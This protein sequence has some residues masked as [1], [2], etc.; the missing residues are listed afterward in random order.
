MSDTTT[1]TSATLEEMLQLYLN[2]LNEKEL[3]AYNIAKAHLGSSFSLE[4]SNGFVKW[5][6]EKYSNNKS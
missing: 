4:K 1:N 3:M 2:S 5:R 6:K